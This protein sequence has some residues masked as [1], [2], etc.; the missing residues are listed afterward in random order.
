MPGGNRYGSPL[1]GDSVNPMQIFTFAASMIWCIGM[2]VLLIYTWMSYVRL[3]RRVLA[4]IH[5]KGNVWMCDDIT[6]PFID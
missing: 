5:L 6:G 4:S 1:V 3:H 2:A